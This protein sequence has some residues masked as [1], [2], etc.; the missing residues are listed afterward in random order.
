MISR[1]DLSRKT[2]VVKALLAK[3]C[4]QM[5][6]SGGERQEMDLKPFP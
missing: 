5:V 2:G 1:V 3:G 4:G 6:K